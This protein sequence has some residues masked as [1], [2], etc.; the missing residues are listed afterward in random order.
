MV[1]DDQRAVVVGESGRAAVQGVP[2]GEFGHHPGPA[3]RARRGSQGTGRGRDLWT[4]TLPTRSA[5]PIETPRDW[6]SSGNVWTSPRGWLPRRCAA[7]RAAG[8]SAVPRPGSCWSLLSYTSVYPQ[9]AAEAAGAIVPRAVPDPAVGTSLAHTRPVH[10]LDRITAGHTVGRV[11]LEPTTWRIMSRP[12]QQ[13][14]GYYL[15]K[16]VPQSL[17]RGHGVHHR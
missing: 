8:S 15:G 2:T 3:R 13:S 1:R 9:V 14:K 10:P 12:D 7:G 16:Q 5:T 11:G 6:S 4:P 17:N